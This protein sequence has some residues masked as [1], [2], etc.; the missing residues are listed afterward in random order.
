MARF[1]ITETVETTYEVNVDDAGYDT[2]TAWRAGDI[3]TDEL[4]QFLTAEP[5][6]DLAVTDRE[7][8]ES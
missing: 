6:V 8:E 5:P 7:I 2:I 3:S 4:H 1:T